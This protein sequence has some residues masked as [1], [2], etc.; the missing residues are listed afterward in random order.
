MPRKGLYPKRALLLNKNNYVQ[1][2][3]GFKIKKNEKIE[4]QIDKKTCKDGHGEKTDT[5][6][7]KSGFANKNIIV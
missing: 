1:C 3:R 7:L 6:T 5:N 2:K 4:G